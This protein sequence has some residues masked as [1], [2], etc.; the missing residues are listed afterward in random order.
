MLCILGATIL[1]TS[2]RIDDGAVLIE[3]DRVATVAPAAEFSCPPGTALVDAHGLV[4]APGFIDLQ[5]NGAFGFDFTTDPA[6]VWHVAARLPRYGVTSF[7]PTI[8]SSPDDVVRSAQRVLLDGAP[9]GVV[10]ATPLG[11]HLEGPFLDPARRG[12]H[13]D[14]HLAPPDRDRIAGWSPDRCVRLVT[15]AP[16]LPGALELVRALTERG[17]VVSA[18]HS[19]ATYAEGV[20]AIEAGVRYGTHLFNAMPPL[21]HR[22]PGL[23]GALLEDPRVIVGLIADGIHVDS[24]VMAL[25]WRAKGAA[26]TSLVTDAMAAL[27]M[28]IGTH[29][30]GGVTCLVDELAP[31]SAEG[32]LA[33]SILSLDKAIRN[34]MSAAHCSLEDAV[35]TVTTVPATLLGLVNRGRIEPGALADLVLLD[36]DVRVAATIA[37]GRLAWAGEGLCLPSGW[38]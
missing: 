4:L 7:L 19:S 32:R 24:V 38:S 29:Q 8:V 13:D 11:L 31:R 28:P 6:S 27:G 18:G 3:G 35:A 20:A 12:V 25:V 9:P 26:G 30:I 2:G 21:L 5:I 33:G 37:A 22:E 17:I 1:T 16:E 36:S 10:G 23:V 14:R 15:L 34:L